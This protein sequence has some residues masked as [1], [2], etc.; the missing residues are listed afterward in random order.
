MTPEKKKKKKG[1]EIFTQ[2]APRM[3]NKHLLRQAR[4]CSGAPLYPLM[5]LQDE[6]LVLPMS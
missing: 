2:A 6:M 1:A 3:C 5:H 4:L